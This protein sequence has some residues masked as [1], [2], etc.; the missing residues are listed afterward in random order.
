[1]GN[2]FSRVTWIHKLLVAVSLHRMDKRTTIEL[3]ST[4]YSR[5]SNLHLMRHILNCLMSKA[6]SRLHVKIVLL[7]FVCKA[8]SRKYRGLFEVNSPENKIRQVLEKK[9]SQQEEQ[10]QV[11]Y[12]TA[13][14]VRRSKRPLSACYSRR[15]WSMETYHKSV[16]GQ[17][18]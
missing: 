7:L 1:M 3:I 11:P 5:F 13:S 8:K 12:G 2:N 18:W 9:W 10:M 17:V 4:W 14:G 16:K 15:K 6:C